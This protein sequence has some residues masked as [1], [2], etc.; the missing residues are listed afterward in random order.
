MTIKET[1]EKAID[2]GYGKVA[3]S[4][5]LENGPL[6]GENCFRI[7]LLDPSFWQCLGKT[8]GLPKEVGAL[9][10]MPIVDGW[11]MLWHRFIDHLASGGSAESF[12]KEL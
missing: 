2:G 11:Q 4:F 8:I 12:F 6:F 3:S 7:M 9:Y 1:I 5:P 10:G